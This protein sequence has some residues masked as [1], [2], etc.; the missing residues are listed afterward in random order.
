MSGSPIDFDALE[1]DDSRSC[2]LRLVERLREDVDDD[3]LKAILDW[4]SKYND[5]RVEGPLLKILEDSNLTDIVR[6]RSSQALC[7]IPTSDTPIQRA[8]WWASGDQILM[9]HALRMSE[10]TVPE[11]ALLVETLA[12]ESSS[13]FHRDAI[14]ALSFCHPEMRFQQIRIK[15]LSHP[16]ALVRKAAAKSL[17]WDQ[18]VIAETALLQ[19]A[20]DDCDDVAQEALDT[21]VWYRSQNL[22]CQLHGLRCSGRPELFDYFNDRFNYVFDD[23]LSAVDRFD[24]DANGKHA[25][26]HY[27]NWLAGLGKFLSFRRIEIAVTAD[28]SESDSQMDMLS[29]K[30][31]ELLHASTDEIIAEYSEPN[32]QR[33]D[34]GDSPYDWSVFAEADRKKLAAFFLASPDHLVRAISAGA[35]AEWNDAKNLVLLMQDKALCVKRAA[36]RY[37]KYHSP[38]AEVEDALLK[39]LSDELTI[40]SFASE[41]LDSYVVHAAHN[42]SLL[43]DTLEKFARDDKREEVRHDAICRLLEREPARLNQL[44]AILQEP[45]MLTWSLHCRLLEHCNAQHVRPPNLESLLEIDD[46]EVQRELAIMR[47]S[48]DSR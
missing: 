26:L 43:L 35:F 21:L 6:D 28:Y 19:A 29:I 40:S 5:F 39:T 46:F 1:R 27:Q 38:N 34:W 45:P 7:E 16:D 13:K 41:T 11:E 12:N 37:A 9:R 2:S 25:F 30:A 23:V 17:F 8:Q 33:S 42:E 32:T 31:K 36:C 3:E 20:N 10:V 15:A 14:E 4:M 47:A 22:L 24:S 48:M 18:P 44:L